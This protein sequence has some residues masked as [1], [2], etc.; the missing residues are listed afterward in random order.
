M[1][2]QDAAFAAIDTNGDG[3]LD[4][5]ELSKMIKDQF[6]LKAGNEEWLTLEVGKFFRMADT[7][8]NGKVSKAEFI[9]FNGRAFDAGVLGQT[10]AMD[11]LQ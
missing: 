3:F 8:H 10:I 4:K 7:D 1:A 5:E 9:D 2:A 11:G 6:P